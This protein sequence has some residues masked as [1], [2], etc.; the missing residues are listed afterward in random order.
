MLAGD[1]EDKDEKDRVDCLPAGK[2]ANPCTGKH[3]DSQ[4]S[5]SPFTI[6][7]Y[8]ETYYSADFNNPAGNTRPSFIFSFR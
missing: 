3:R 2:H 7:G 5:L 4:G 8:A 1:L 6:S